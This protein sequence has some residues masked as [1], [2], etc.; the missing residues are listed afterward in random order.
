LNRETE[1]TLKV[2]GL[3]VAG[4]LAAILIGIV[5]AMLRSGSKPRR[6]TS[7]RI[8]RDHDYDFGDWG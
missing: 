7:R 6:R 8:G 4:V 3:I 5:D 2:V 1:D